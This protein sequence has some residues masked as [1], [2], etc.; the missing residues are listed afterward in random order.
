MH[1]SYTYSEGARSSR[2][3]VQKLSTYEEP[4]PSDEMR[5]WGIIS[6]LEEEMPE[7][8]EQPKAKEQPEAKEQPR[9]TN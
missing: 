4:K 1:I 2:R 3:R 9:T 8:K 6:K 7:A 5:E